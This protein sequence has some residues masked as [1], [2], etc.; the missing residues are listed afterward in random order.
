M[1]N[2]RRNKVWSIYIYP[3]F[4][5]W[6]GISD[7]YP[8]WSGI[9]LFFGTVSGPTSTGQFMHTPTCEQCPKRRRHRINTFALETQQYA[10]DGAQHLISGATSHQ[11][12]TNTRDGAPSTNQESSKDTPT[13]RWAKIEAST[14][15]RKQCSTRLTRLTLIQPRTRRLRQPPST[16]DATRNRDCTT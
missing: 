14:Q 1:G 3:G 6:P 4:W 2:G 13:K 5:T 16:N 11:I 9:L 7:F 15:G 10:C 12:S 8:V